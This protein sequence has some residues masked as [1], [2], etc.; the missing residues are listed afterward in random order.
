MHPDPNT[1]PDYTPAANYTRKQLKRGGF[2]GLANPSI[3][4][5]CEAD[6]LRPGLDC[7]KKNCKPAYKVPCNP[8]I[9]PMGGE[10][11]WHMTVNKPQA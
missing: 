11:G 3:Q 6:G 2:D 8:E 5:G 7:D 4:C 9:C 10:C 1:P